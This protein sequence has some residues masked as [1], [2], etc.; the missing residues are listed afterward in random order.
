LSLLTFIL[1]KTKSLKAFSKDAEAYFTQ[2]LV[3]L[4]HENG[5]I[6][7]KALEIFYLFINALK[8]CVINQQQN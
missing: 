6:K 1:Q 7:S 8:S 3:L 5:S 4:A 2:V